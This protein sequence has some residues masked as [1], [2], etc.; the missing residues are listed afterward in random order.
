MLTIYWNSS[1][2]HEVRP[3]SMYDGNR[4]QPLQASCVIIFIGLL[5]SNVLI[6]I[7]CFID[8]SEYLLLGVCE[9]ENQVGAN[10][11]RSSR[12]GSSLG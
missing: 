1:N 6:Q 2:I 11:A 10:V 3:S 8:S 4:E 5:L 12:T 7:A 9:L